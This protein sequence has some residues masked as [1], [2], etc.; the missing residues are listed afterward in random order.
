MLFNSRQIVKE[1]N[2]TT[3]LDEA[4]SIVVQQSK[5]AT[6]TLA[7]SESGKT[8]SV[9]MGLWIDHRKAVIVTVSDTGEETSVIESKVEKQP[10]RFAGVRS[11]TPYES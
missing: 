4:L 6:G 11:I 10:G 9:I 8:I 7:E 2:N 5:S 3:Q 1:I